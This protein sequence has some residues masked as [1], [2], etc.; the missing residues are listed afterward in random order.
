MKINKNT[1]KITAILFG[2]SIIAPVIIYVI[3]FGDKQLSDKPELWSAFGDYLGG[4]L[5][6]IIALFG[7]IIL[8]YLTYEVSKQS[9]DENRNLFLFQ[10]RIIAFQK[11]AKITSEFES[12]QHRMKIHNDLM[13]KLGSVGNRELATEQYI[14]AM[15]ILHISLSGLTVVTSNFPLNYGH[16]FEYDF[17]CAEYENLNK[18][19]FEYFKSM[20]L[21]KDYKKGDLDFTEK[22]LFGQFKKVLIELKKEISTL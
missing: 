6:P 15:E 10:Q 14:K 18:R 4:I 11:I 5:G 2:I 13:V 17:E 21:L 22:E 19:A 1:L 12:A 8:G 7:T 3:N 16:L 9:S 20:D